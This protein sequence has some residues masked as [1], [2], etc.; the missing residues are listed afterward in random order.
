MNQEKINK[1]I[2]TRLEKLEKVTFSNDKKIKQST[3]VK[4]SLSDYI[5]G[6]RD[7]G[8]FK[9]PLVPQEV[10]KKLES[11]YHCDLSRV[12]VELIRLQKRGMIRKA[13]KLIGGKKY[14]AYV[15]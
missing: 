2:F 11:T 15:S 4:K 5:I 8:G 12:K 7:R 6:L 9:K 14:I 1:Q 10:H 3:S 13:S